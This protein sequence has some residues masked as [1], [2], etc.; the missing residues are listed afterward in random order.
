MELFKK[1]AFV[2]GAFVI[3]GFILRVVFSVLGTIFSLSFKGLL[4][5]AA[6]AIP[7]YLIAEKKF[8]R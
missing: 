1:I 5:V 6:I 8:L 2:V 7:I 3:A 4:L